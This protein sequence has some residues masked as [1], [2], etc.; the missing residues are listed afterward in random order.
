MLGKLARWLRMLGYDTELAS[1][2]EKD[3]DILERARVEG[4]VLLTRDKELGGHKGVFLLESSDI[5]EQMRSLTS[6]FTLE[7]S[8]SLVPRFCS[9]CNGRLRDAFPD[10]L[11]EGV[12]SGWACVDCGQKYW[13]GS[14]WVG[15][16]KF[17]KRLKRNS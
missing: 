3:A 11:P 8:E 2:K 9:L 10:E 17:I 15:V 7:L 1:N 5:F 4:R 16:E 12:S 14:H 13:H 6:E